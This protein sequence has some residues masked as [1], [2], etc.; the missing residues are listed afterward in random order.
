M[1]SFPATS[2]FNHGNVGGKLIEESGSELEKLIEFVN[3]VG[4]YYLSL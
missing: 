3:T 4:S 1:Q 2:K